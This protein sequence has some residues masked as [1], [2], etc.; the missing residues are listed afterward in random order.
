MSSPDGSYTEERSQES[1]LKVLAAD[2]D[3]E[4]DDEEPLPALGTCKALYAFEGGQ[5]WG[6]SAVPCQTWSSWGQSQVGCR[7]AP[8]A[9]RTEAQ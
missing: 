4:F 9:A 3:D 7:G 2:F 6:R 1:E 5:P 8:R